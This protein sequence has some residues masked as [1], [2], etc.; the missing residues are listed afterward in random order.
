MAKDDAEPS[1]PAPLPPL[2]RLSLNEAV[3]LIV[4]LLP[5]PDADVVRTAIRNALVNGTLRDCPCDSPYRGRST[6]PDTWR[7]WF[8][9]DRVNMQTGEVSFPPRPGRLRLGLMTEGYSLGRIT[10]PSIRPQLLPPG[11][12][13]LF[14]D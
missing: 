7:R 10:P 6:E 11:S 1:T 2:D 5:L 14:R 4:V 13:R 9:E 8:N 12:A 3:A